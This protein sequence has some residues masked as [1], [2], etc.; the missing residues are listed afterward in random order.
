MKEGRKVYQLPHTITVVEL[1]AFAYGWERTHFLNFDNLA[2]FEF[3]GFEV[4][5]EELSSCGSLA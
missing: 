3:V 4:Q 1:N 2:Y 5:Q